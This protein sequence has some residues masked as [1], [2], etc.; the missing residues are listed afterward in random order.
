MGPS[1]VRGFMA[2]MLC[3]DQ[4]GINKGISVDKYLAKV[5]VKGN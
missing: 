5:V 1:P 2:A 3:S 4:L